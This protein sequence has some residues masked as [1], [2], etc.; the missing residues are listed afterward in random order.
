[1]NALQTPGEAPWM[2]VCRSGHSATSVLSGRLPKFCRRCG[3]QVLVACKRCQTAFETNADG[4]P[5]MYCFECGAEFPWRTAAVEHAKRTIEIAVAA[6]Q[7]DDGASELGREFV[8]DLAA[9]RI[10]TVRLHA[11]FDWLTRHN[12]E[13]RPAFA[14]MADSIGSD[15]VREWLTRNGYGPTGV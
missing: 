15:V 2:G 5:P 12:A 6:Q 9:G 3:D 4:T 14:A 11:V 1:M 8:D 13:A 7:W 10:T